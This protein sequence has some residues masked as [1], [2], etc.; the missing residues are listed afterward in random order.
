MWQK[1]AGWWHV[2]S[3]WYSSMQ[4]PTLRRPCRPW[5]LTWKME[6][7]A[8]SKALWTSSLRLGM[9]YCRKVCVKE[10]LIRNR[11]SFVRS[12]WSCLI[13]DVWMIGQKRCHFH[14]LFYKN[15]KISGHVNIRIELWITFFIINFYCV[16]WLKWEICLLSNNNIIIHLSAHRLRNH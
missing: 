15:R 5:H 16:Y 13:L 3:E 11:F 12:D 10:N 7:T 6:D 8:I 9:W 1:P 2:T 4:L 14:I